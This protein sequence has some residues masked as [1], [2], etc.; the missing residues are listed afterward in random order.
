M[1]AFLAN[2]WFWFGTLGSAAFW[3]LRTEPGGVA[4]IATIAILT[5]INA[6]LLAT[7]A[8]AIV[9]GLRRTQRPEPPKD[10]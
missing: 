8:A 7:L 2:G 3:L 5:V 10:H 1:R 9:A 6:V 4:L